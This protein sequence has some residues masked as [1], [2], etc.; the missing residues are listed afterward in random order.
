MTPDYFRARINAI[1]KLI[2]EIPVSDEKNKQGITQ[3][4]IYSGRAD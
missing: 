4:R 1:E 2:S 3:E